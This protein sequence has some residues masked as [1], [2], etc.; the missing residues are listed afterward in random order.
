MKN[1]L[2]SFRLGLWRELIFWA[3]VNHGMA[4]TKAR[5][6]AQYD[7]AMAMQ[8]DIF[9]LEP[10]PYEMLRFYLKYVVYE[11]MPGADIRT[12]WTYFYSRARYYLRE[13]GQQDI[14]SKLVWLCCYPH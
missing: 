14:P 12:K 1:H 3:G 13:K 4:T 5:Y 2:D 7:R 10:Q 8:D 6:D 9:T 11:F